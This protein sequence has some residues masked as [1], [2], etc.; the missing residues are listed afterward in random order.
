ME[1]KEKFNIKALGKGLSLIL[2][3]FLG[4]NIISNIFSFFIKSKILPAK[5]NNIY[6]L[7][8]YL[9]LFIIFTLLYKK[10]LIHDFNKFKKDFKKDIKIAFKY[11]IRGVFIMYLTNYLLIFIFHLSKSV[12]ELQNIE[13]IKNNMITQTIIIILLAPFLEEIVFRLSFKKMTKDIKLYSIITG[14]LFGFVHVITSLNNPIMILLTIPYSSVGIGL[15]YAYRKTDN[16]FS[17][18]TM[19]MLHNTFTIAIIIITILG[20]IL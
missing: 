14:V 4:A 6:Y 5:Y 9:I 16:I 11:Y 15:G 18:I 8:I 3:Y 12:N 2:A 13:M 1:R 20:G 19:H 10:E 7:L 17:S